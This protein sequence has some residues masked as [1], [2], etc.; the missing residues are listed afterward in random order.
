MRLAEARVL[1]YRK[2]IE[3]LKPRDGRDVQ[4]NEG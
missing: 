1:H 3:R 4:L 2:V